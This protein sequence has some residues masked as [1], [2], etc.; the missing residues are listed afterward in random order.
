MRRLITTALVAV[1]TVAVSIVLL[2]GSAPAGHADSE[3]VPPHAQQLAR[4]ISAYEM[5][6]YH[7]ETWDQ[8]H[9]ARALAT[10]MCDGIAESSDVGVTWTSRH[11]DLAA[12]RASQKPNEF[13]LSSMRRLQTA[14]NGLR[15]IWSDD[16]TQYVR[17]VSATH[18]N[19][20]R[21]HVMKT[22]RDDKLIGFTSVQF[23]KDVWR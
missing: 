2:S 13:E 19:C 15:E 5:L 9:D 22:P 7:F 8:A 4:M 10:E 1:A 6:R 12:D 11:F 14:A 20:T 21:C 23:S 16:H 17:A 3:A 18:A